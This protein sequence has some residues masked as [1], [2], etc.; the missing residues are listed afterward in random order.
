MKDWVIGG[1]YGFC[2]FLEETFGRTP[3]LDKPDC[4]S[5]IFIDFLLW[6]DSL[7]KFIVELATFSLGFVWT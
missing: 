3:V 2:D 1:K 5:W 4:I 7:L 6:E